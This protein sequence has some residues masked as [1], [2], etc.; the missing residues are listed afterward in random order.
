MD[1]SV[2][3]IVIYRC[4]LLLLLSKIWGLGL[5]LG[6]IS[7]WFLIGQQP[8]AE[9]ICLVNFK[10]ISFLNSPLKLLFEENLKRIRMT[11]VSRLKYILIVFQRVAALFLSS[12]LWYSVILFSYPILLCYSVFFFLR[13]VVVLLL[14]LDGHHCYMN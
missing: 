12:N 7:C 9:F 10:S 1:F 11:S 13:L 2:K 14:D 4:C 3:V 5:W 6:L 8:S